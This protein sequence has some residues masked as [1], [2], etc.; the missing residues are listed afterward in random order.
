MSEPDRASVDT[1]H[2]IANELFAEHPTGFE[3]SSDAY[4]GHVHRGIDL[5]GLQID[6]D[7]PTAK[8]LGVAAFFHDAGI[9]LDGTF[10]YLGPSIQRA[11]DHLD[12][13]DEGGRELVRT[14]IFEHHRLRRA[15]S[16][17][18]LVEAFR[19][20][21]L[22]DLT[23]GLIPSPGVSFRDYRRLA[24]RHPS[25]GFRWKLT[26]IFVRWTLRHPL[27]PLPMVKR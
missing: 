13:V 1:A 12:G 15:K 19:R 5:V 3:A 20:A 24:G 9:W 25:Y 2:R 10:D 17:H 14:V 22:T 4:R 23:G 21:D 26:V 8:L 18:A 27:R 7:A 16:D 11:L 6:L